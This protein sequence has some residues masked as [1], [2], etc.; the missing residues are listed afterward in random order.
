[1]YHIKK[2]LVL[3]HNNIDGRNGLK[4]CLY[5][6]RVGGF[7][8]FVVT[9]ILNGEHKYALCHVHK[10]KLI[11]VQNLLVELFCYPT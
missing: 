10:M 9:P 3:S 11:C 4:P 8:S 7:D 1:M 2:L 6:T 5:D